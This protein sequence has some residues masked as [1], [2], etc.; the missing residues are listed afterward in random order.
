MCLVPNYQYILEYEAIARGTDFGYERK[1]NYPTNS[2][3]NDNN[4]LL[5]GRLGK[6]TIE[7]KDCLVGYYHL[8]NDMNLC[9]NIKP[10]GHY[11]DEKSRTYK[12]CPASC[13]ECNAPIDS[14]HMNCLT[15]KPNY[16]LTEDTYSC[17][18]KDKENYYLDIDD[19]LR[20]CYYKCLHCSKKATN[21]TFMNC[22]ECPQHY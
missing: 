14:T 4:V 10:K 17:Y 18:T 8:E 16:Y 12:A 20:R 3:I 6:I 9:T 13:E 7:L 5:E 15:C 22:L 2:I 11:I 1:I 21:I 19:I